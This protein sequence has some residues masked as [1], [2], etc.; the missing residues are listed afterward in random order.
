M[1]VFNI[2]E[3][4]SRRIEFTDGTDETSRLTKKLVKLKGKRKNRSIS[5]VSAT[6]LSR[7]TSGINQQINTN[8]SLKQIL[9]DLKLAAQVLIS[10]ILSPRDLMSYELTYKLNES[11]T[12]KDLSSNVIDTI[13]QYFDK[14]YCILDISPKILERALFIS[15]SYPLLVLPENTVDIVI[16]SNCVV[17]KENY[18]DV[19]SSIE[20]PLGIIDSKCSIINK[21]TNVSDNFN[22]L[23][24]PWI[25]D[26]RLVHSLEDILN[27]C[28]TTRD[29]CNETQYLKRKYSHVP[30]ETVKLPS[31]EGLY[32]EPIAMKLPSES[33]VPIHVPGDPSEHLGYF[34]LV[35]NNGYPVSGKERRKEIDKLRASKNMCANDRSATL[36]KETKHAIY[37]ELLEP[38]NFSGTNQEIYT[39]LIEEDLTRRIKN[40]IYGDD[41]EVS[42]ISTIAS[43]MFARAL[44]EKR[45]TVLY[46]PAKLL[47]YI[48]FDFN[49]NGVG[50]TLLE[51][52][53][54]LASL[55]SVLL[56][57]NTMA[58]VKN[59]V[60]RTGVKIN[61][62]QDD[63][64][65]QGTVEFLLN[66]F[67]KSHNQ[68]F[69]I[70]LTNPSDITD[71]IQ[72]S[73]I[74]VA[75][76]GN[77][78][79]PETSIDITDKSRSVYKPDS[80]LE[81]QMRRRHYMSLG[82]PPE[83]IDADMN[84]DFATMIVSSNLLTAK[85]ITIYQKLFTSYLTRFVKVY[86]RY[87]DKL[88]Q[89]IRDALEEN[90]SKVHLNDVIEAIELSLPEPDNSKLENQITAF[91]TYSNAL[92]TMLRAYFST[93]MLGR[94]IDN[95]I[96]DAIEPTIECIKSYY[97]RQ[98]LRNNNVLPELDKLTQ[99]DSGSNILDLNTVHKEH[100]D[101][102]IKS[103]GTL[104]IG[105]RKVGREWFSK[106]EKDQIDYEA[107]Q[108]QEN[109]ELGG[110][111]T[112][113]ETTVEET[114][115]EE[116]QPE[117]LTS[118]EEETVEEGEEEGEE[119][120]GGE[121]EGTSE[122]V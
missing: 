15:G 88:K 83:L 81:N 77:T 70:G 107:K 18:S 114:P 14:E 47:T 44:S 10:G 85:Q 13:K 98:W 42:D 113:E 29:E 23:K 117:E 5:D 112:E 11:I 4:R 109:E 1:S 120:E 108:M 28:Y 35:D 2:A 48:A 91:S 84:I 25:N 86:I 93:D 68:S 58:S 90:K 119:E 7:I 31:D 92:E 62:D 89:S 100:L 9:P 49:Q 110:E 99:Q 6:E 34:I 80:E 22:L 96:E 71:A 79:Y 43:I 111:T 94:T 74:D 116:Q 65:P 122:E 121:E 78:A 26:K 52:G 12:D 24:K 41:A 59:S 76:S 63:P 67:L 16:N 82:L 115:V 27:D 57:S 51:D 32:G 72:R 3:K 17:S 53:A 30:L 20:S 40:G 46:I 64:D 19:L 50:K 38:V 106:L 55:R 60:P 73:S 54:L 102:I 103:V 37:G 104:L 33:V 118:E 21:Y 95:E 105:I 39:C 69:P 66:E 45:T 101:A 97:Q 56:F 87:S 36:I 8:E 75:V 61:L